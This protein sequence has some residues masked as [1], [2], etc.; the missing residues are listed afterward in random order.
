MGRLFLPEEGSIGWSFI[1]EAT[2]ELK[3]RRM[4]K[5][6]TGIPRR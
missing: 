3:L 5:I 2:F 1:E 6:S 4:S